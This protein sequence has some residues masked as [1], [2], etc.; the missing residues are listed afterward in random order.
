L[1]EFQDELRDKV[2]EQGVLM[3][4]ICA[5][6]RVPHSD[7]RPDATLLA[8]AD[9]SSRIAICHDHLGLRAERV[10]YELP[11]QDR[12]LRQ[13]QQRALAIARK[14]THDESTD[15]DRAFARSLIVPVWIIV[16]VEG[17]IDIAG[18]IQSLVGQ[19]HID[20]PKEWGPG[21]SL[22]AYGSGVLR[23]LADAGVI[24]A[25]ERRF[26]A[27]LMT[28]P[29][30]KDEGLPHHSDERAASIFRTII[31]NQEIA[32]AGMRSIATIAR[33][34]KK[35]LAEVA[36]ELILREYRTQ[37]QAREVETSRAVLQ[38][39]LAAQTFWNDWT[40]SGR[41]PDQLKIAALEELGSDDIGTS[42]AEL[43]MLANY[44][45]TRHRALIRPAYTDP[46]EAERVLAEIARDRHGIEVLA[47]VVREGR[48]GGKLPR[49]D[50]EGA[51]VTDDNGDGLPVTDAWL[52]TTFKT[53]KTDDEEPE[54]ITPERLL[55]LRRGAFV[56]EVDQ[57]E[58]KMHEVK[59]VTSDTGQS[60]IKDLGW[61]TH[62][63]EDVLTRLEGVR[64]DLTVY[65]ALW[66]E[67]NI[68]AE[69]SDG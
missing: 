5:A 26:F 19:I 36:A 66:S 63:V 55:A 34:Q 24:S 11:K 52:R 23:A 46:R 8:A 16:K 41:N 18:A 59:E 67:R 65:G 69:E 35:K 7:G 1:I 44:W 38:R 10:I 6:I 3:P 62:E 58:T 14:P 56:A 28:R 29:Q 50:D 27:G 64:R 30:A 47:A 15:K 12:G 48:R 43:A 53:D 57:L 40:I 60:L 21:A 68:A 37:Y 42:Q 39:V 2:A 4:V 22:D 45:L 61:P 31:D 9:G 33:I 20:P 17:A 25:M 13:M 32:K 51:V 54:A 49:V